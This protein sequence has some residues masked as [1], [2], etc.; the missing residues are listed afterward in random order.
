MVYLLVWILHKYT[1]N[2]KFS[3]YGK[4]DGYRNDW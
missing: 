2:T 1:H 3:I 4:I